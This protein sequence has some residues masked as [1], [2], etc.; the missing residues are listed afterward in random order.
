MLV[1]CL[2]AVPQLNE[3]LLFNFRSSN[4]VKRGSFSYEVL[5]KNYGITFFS[6]PFNIPITYLATV[7]TKSQFFSPYCEDSL[8]WA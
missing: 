4:V 7:H 2:W 6:S 8:G 3:C 5:L 1:Y